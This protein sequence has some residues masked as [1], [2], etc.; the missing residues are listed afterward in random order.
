MAVWHNVRVEVEPNANAAAGAD[1]QALEDAC[2]AVNGVSDVLVRRNRR[3]LVAEGNCGLARPD[4]IAERLAQLVRA[5][6]VN[7]EVLV[8]IYRV[9]DR[10]VQHRITQAGQAQME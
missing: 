4:E 2:Y 3:G 8:R 1:E 6:F 7:S 10:V 5:Q 9:P